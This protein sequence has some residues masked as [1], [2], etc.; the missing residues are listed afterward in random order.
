VTK[1][2]YIRAMDVLHRVCIVVAASCLVIMTLIIPWGVFSRYV[3]NR[4]P[5]S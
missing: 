2:S 5:F 3:L 4:W 1:T